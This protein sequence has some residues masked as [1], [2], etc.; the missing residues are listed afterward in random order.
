MAILFPPPAIPG[1]GNSGGISFMLEDRESRGI[2]FLAEQ[3]RRFVEASKSRPEL[4]RV[5]TTAQFDVPQIFAEVNREMVLK[6]GVS[7]D[8]VYQTM[9]AYMGGIFINYFNRFGRVWQV[10]IQAEGSF[11]NDVE[12]L[13]RFYVKNDSGGMVP[14][15]AIVENK[16]IYGPEFT[17]RFNQHNTAQM[18][19][20]PAPGYSGGQA[21]AATEALFDEVMPEGMGYDYMGMAFQAKEASEGVSPALIFGFSLLMVFLILAAQYESWALPF[22]VLLTTPVAVMGA[23]LGLMSRSFSNDLYTQ[24]GLVMLIGLSAKNAILIVEFARARMAEGCGIEEAALDAARSRLRP[25]LM[26]AFAFILGVL[27]LVT[28][29]GSG[30][31][32]RQVLGTVVLGGMLAATFISIFMVPT[33]F[34]V[35]EKVSHYFSSEGESDSSNENIT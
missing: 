9:Q 13:G 33:T 6:Q 27:P 16:K 34:A 30:A 14:I 1:V 35:V 3:T 25:I 15:S 20:I 2:P 12:K 10:Y 29:S 32:S 17:M 22:A 24:I 31:A 7:L 8:S 26:T 23:F 21:M 4:G 19:I 11:R 28:A 18:L 5:A